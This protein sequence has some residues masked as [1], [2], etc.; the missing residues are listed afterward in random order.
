MRVASGMTETLMSVLVPY[1]RFLESQ[2]R[3]R[4]ITAELTPRDKPPTMEADV[5]P[6]P[7]SGTSFCAPTATSTMPTEAIIRLPR[8]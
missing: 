2:D 3:R 5:A 4:R 6:L 7:S 1:S 8:T